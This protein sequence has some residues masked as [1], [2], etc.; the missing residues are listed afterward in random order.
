[1]DGC[2][3]KP[4]RKEIV[5]FMDEKTKIQIGRQTDKQVD[6]WMERQTHQTVRCMKRQKDSFLDRQTDG[7]KEG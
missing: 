2:K 6:R 7:R 4:T 1:M 5:R 3:E